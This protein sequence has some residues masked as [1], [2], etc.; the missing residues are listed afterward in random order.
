MGIPYNIFAPKDQIEHVLSLDDFSGHHTDA[1]YITTKE[2][3]IQIVKVPSGC[4]DAIQV[5]DTHVNSSFKK[6]LENVYED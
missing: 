4:T 5:L 2:R 1:M 3:R 6:H